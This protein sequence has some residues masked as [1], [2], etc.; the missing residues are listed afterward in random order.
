MIEAFKRLQ[1]ENSRALYG[2]CAG[3]SPLAAV[4]D[5]AFAESSL[6]DISRRSFQRF[7][8]TVRERFLHEM[9]R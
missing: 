5:L 1:A 7:K 4:F 6:Q 9:E 3:L 8:Q 2:R